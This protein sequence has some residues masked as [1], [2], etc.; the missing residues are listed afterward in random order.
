M[1][2]KKGTRVWIS[3]SKLAFSLNLAFSIIF[4]CHINS[5]IGP[6]CSSRPAACTFGAVC[7]AQS[8]SENMLFSFH[9]STSPWKLASQ[10]AMYSCSQRSIICFHLMKDSPRS[11][12]NQRKKIEWIRETKLLPCQEKK[13]KMHNILYKTLWLKY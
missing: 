5:S 3:E 2:G 7:T 13:I 8:G 9:Y 10:S 12:K 11:A 1:N 4:S 6:R